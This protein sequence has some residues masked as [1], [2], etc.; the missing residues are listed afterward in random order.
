LHR[1]I[2]RRRHL[3]HH[4]IQQ[5]RLVLTT[6]ASGFIEASSCAAIMWRVVVL[7]GS[8]KFC[9]RECSHRVMEM[10]SPS[11]ATCWGSISTPQHDGTVGIIL[12]RCLKRRHCRS[13][14][15]AEQRDEIAPFHCRCSRASN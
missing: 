7:S 6:I 9:L 10:K 8:P 5:P 11:K 3:L 14:R 12:R 4:Q 15:A 1:L 2:A 13:H